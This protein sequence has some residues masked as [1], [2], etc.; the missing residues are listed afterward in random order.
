MSRENVV[1]SIFLIVWISV[2]V[3]ILLI[4]DSF[5]LLS[6]IFSILV[7]LVVWFFSD[8]IQSPSMVMSYGYILAFLIP[9]PFYFWFA[10]DRWYFL[11]DY[12]F[13]KSLFLSSFAFLGAG[14]GGLVPI[15]RLNKRIFEDT[16]FF[17]KGW[18]GKRISVTLL[19]LAIAFL[20]PK[21]LLNL[22]QAGSERFVVN[23]PFVTGILF[24]ATTY[25]PSVCM[26][27]LWVDF[28]RKR[29]I[30]SLILF[31]ICAGAFSFSAIILGWKG[32]FFSTGVIIGFTFLSTIYFWKQRY[33]II[34]VVGLCFILLGSITTD[35]ALRYRSLNSGGSGDVVYANK[36]ESKIA[37]KIFRVDGNGRCAT[38]VSYASPQSLS[39]FSPDG[40]RDEIKHYSGVVDYI[41]T[42]IFRIPMWV[43]TS[44]GG[45]GPGGRYLLGGMVGTF[46]SY[47][48]YGFL[49]NLLY[50]LMCS[51]QGKYGCIAIYS[52]MASYLYVWGENFTFPVILKRLLV[53]FISVYFVDV[54]LG[55]INQIKKIS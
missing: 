15:K 45:S 20:I 37:K 27:F 33:A 49:L 3:S 54:V 32:A 21:I 43:P 23:I 48:A 4:L 1:C 51:S 13:A 31:S 46:I 42:V 10:D 30:F 18:E 52:L 2:F 12:E 40:I 5:V 6:F 39:L 35:L 7:V 19:I 8:G 16:P 9:V 11:E 14:I 41:D 26:I 25:I 55:R 28:L 29:N 22:G 44:V 36:Y 50:L 17:I 24:Y 53:I 47:F 38:V 34:I